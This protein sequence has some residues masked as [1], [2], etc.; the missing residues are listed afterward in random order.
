M[1]HVTWG[2][3]SLCCKGGIATIT[4]LLVIDSLRAGVSRWVY[5]PLC[6]LIL[7]IKAN[8]PSSLDNNLRHVVDFFSE[9]QTRCRVLIPRETWNF[10]SNIKA[11]HSDLLNGGQRGETTAILL[12]SNHVH[13][14]SACQL[15][16]S[17]T[18]D[19]QGGRGA[20][21]TKKIAD[22]FLVLKL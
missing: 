16:M 21:S 7:A 4:W 10:N 20:M 19:N 15:N 22:L 13:L 1:E 9:Q 3:T 11:Y 8:Y 14:A 6:Y 5:K 17:D 18:G 12:E 2:Q